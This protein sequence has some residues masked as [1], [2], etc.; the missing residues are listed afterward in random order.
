LAFSWEDP[1]WQVVVEGGIEADDADRIVDQI[2]EQLAAA[3][4]QATRVV[5]L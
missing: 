5:Q 3:T 4:G 1:G 2:A